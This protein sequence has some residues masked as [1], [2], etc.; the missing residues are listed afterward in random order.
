MALKS[1]HMAYLNVPK[2]TVAGCYKFLDSVQANSGST[3]GYTS[4]GGGHAT[5]AVGLLCRMYL[6]WKKDEPALIRGVET[7]SKWAPSKTDMYYNYYATQVM[8]H[9]GGPLWDK[10]NKTMRDHLVATQK[11]GKGQCDNTGSWHMG[12]GH[13][14]RAWHA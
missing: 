13:G 7:I 10:W 11:T 6:G 3:Y 2:N 12:A 5:T 1:G 8:R 9:H 4:P 14:A